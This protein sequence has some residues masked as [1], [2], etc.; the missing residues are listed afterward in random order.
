MKIRYSVLV[1]K[2]GDTFVAYTPQLDLSSCG[3]TPKRSPGNA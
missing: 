3:A 2:E 1:F